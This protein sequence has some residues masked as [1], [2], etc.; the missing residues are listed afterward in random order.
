M[1]YFKRINN[2]ITPNPDLPWHETK[3]QA[4]TKMDWESIFTEMGFV[5]DNDPYPNHKDH[6]SL[7][8]K[9]SKDSKLRLSYTHRT[10]LITISINKDDDSYLYP[11]DYN[12]LRYGLDLL[13]NTIR[14]LYAPVDVLTLKQDP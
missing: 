14:E 1:T 2:L 11:V 3:P 7:H 13:L 8:F 9:H 12:S 6:Y 10:N 4:L 5:D